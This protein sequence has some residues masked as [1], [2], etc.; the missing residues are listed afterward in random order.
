MPK[1]TF[2]PR[3]ISS[4]HLANAFIASSLGTFSSPLFNN[5]NIEYGPKPLNNTEN[6]LQLMSGS[7]FIKL[8]P[9]SL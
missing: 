8:I 1:E 2:K 9:Y 7:A 4:Y 6:R 5:T 3:S